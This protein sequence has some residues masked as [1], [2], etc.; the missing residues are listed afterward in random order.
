MSPLHGCLAGAQSN[1][2]WRMCRTGARSHTTRRKVRLGKRV[3]YL[4]KFES[5]AGDPQQIQLAFVRASGAGPTRWCTAVGTPEQQGRPKYPACPTTELHPGSSHSWLESQLLHGRLSSAFQLLHW[6]PTKWVNRRRSLYGARLLKLNWRVADVSEDYTDL[7]LV[8]PFSYMISCGP[9]PLCTDP[10]GRSP[11]SGFP[12][13]KRGDRTT[14]M[15]RA[16]PC[17]LEQD[18]PHRDGDGK[19]AP[20]QK[21]DAFTSRRSP[22]IR[23]DESTS[24]DGAPP[25]PLAR[26]KYLHRRDETRRDRWSLSPVGRCCQLMV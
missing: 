5:F 25:V 9:D 17:I 13:H 24:T 7:S 15:L 2:P 1:H 22:P 11:R 21:P 23:P 16:L 3:P 10:L 4:G 26:A 8:S 19:S 20:G 18:I 14:P 12:L 6:F